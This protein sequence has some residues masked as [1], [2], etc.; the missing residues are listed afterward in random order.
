[1]S[2]FFLRLAFLGFVI[3]TTAWCGS[4]NA[5]TDPPTEP[6]MAAINGFVRIGSTPIQGAQVLLT[7]PGGQRTIRSAAD[8]G[9]AFSDLPP[10]VYV[11][12]AILAGVTCSS[13]STEM[14]P[15]ETLTTSIDCASAA[16]HVTIS[17]TGSVLGGD[18]P[19]GGI[20]VTLTGVGSEGA[21]IERAVT[22][23]STGHFTFAQLPQGTYD[24]TASAPGFGCE[25]IV[26]LVF[27]GTGLIVTEDIRCTVEEDGEAPPPPTMV[28]MGKIAF[29]RDGRIMVLDLDTNNVFHFIDGLA[30]SW[31][32][33]GRRLAFQRPAC[34]DRSLPPYADCDD[35]W[36]V[37]ADG[38]GLSPVTNYEWVHDQD[39]VWSPDGSRVAFVRFV[40]GPDQ[41]YLVVADVDPPSALWSETVPS[42]WH[43]YS[44]PT[45]SPDGTQVAFTCEGPPPRWEFDLCAVPSTRDLGYQGGQTGGVRRIT[46]GTGVDSD[47]AWSPDGTRLAFT[48]DREAAGR[49]YV[50][51]VGADGNGYEALVVGKDPA[52]SPDG[53]R[54]VFVGDDAPG[55]HI[56]NSDGTGLVRITDD[57]ADNAPS[58]GR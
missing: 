49:S 40:H 31:S 35:I 52:W 17:L 56:V 9:F 24:L 57:P 34:P 10:G 46:T 21:S 27:L 53:T 4:E 6:R 18:A 42:V 28:G 37:D 29:E 43:P 19:L 47:P 45:W 50:A 39:P 54:I 22:T 5:P 55:L 1:M 30:P 14:E 15:G 33:D 41:S 44:D 38:S 32:P 11:M 3:A 48:T 51:L 23:D 36:V 12:R 8:G 2:C 7:G 20:Q 13:T 58:W 16:P 26:A 25:S